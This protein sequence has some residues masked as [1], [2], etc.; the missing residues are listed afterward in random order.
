ME[1]NYVIDGQASLLQITPLD[2]T[3][4]PNYIA[5]TV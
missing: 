2:K 4:K 1:N 3:N 5:M